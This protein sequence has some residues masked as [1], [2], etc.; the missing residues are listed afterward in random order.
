VRTVAIKRVYEPA[1]AGDGYR[2]LIDRLWPRGVSKERARLDLWLRWIAPSAEL[3][4][5]F[6]H[7]PA[8]WSAFVKRYRAELRANNAGVDELRRAIAKK[9]K[10]T[11]VYAARDQEH[12]DAVALRQILKL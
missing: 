1:A 11:L 3:R 5:W 9:R 7:D 6:G 2:I 12:N 4:T 8:R 10:V